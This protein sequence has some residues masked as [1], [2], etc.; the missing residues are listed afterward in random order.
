[1][2][3]SGRKHRRERTRRG[4]RLLK[5]TLLLLLHQSAAHGYMLI[6]QLGTFGLDGVHPSAAYR[7]LRDMEAKGWISS[8]WDTERAQGPP[9]RVYSLS[10]RGNQ[11]LGAYI[12]DL[13]QA[14]SQMSD[15]MDVYDQHMRLG[16]GEHHGG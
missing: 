15:L 6:D 4:A 5:P 12:Q 13:R 9:R 3:R 11:V 8:N 14:H 1:M 10:A 2:S 7:A 16:E